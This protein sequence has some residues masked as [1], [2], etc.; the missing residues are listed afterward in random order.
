MENDTTIGTAENTDLRGQDW[1]PAEVSSLVRDY[2]TMLLKELYGVDYS[3]TEHRTRLLPQLCGRSHASV[4]RKCQNVSAVLVQHG[5]PYIDGYKPLGNYQA[6]LASETVSYLTQEPYVGAALAAAPKLKPCCLEK[7]WDSLDVPTLREECPDQLEPPS[8]DSQWLEDGAIPNIARTQATNET[9]HGLGLQFVLHV[10]R[11]ILIDAGRRDLADRVQILSRW[12]NHS[13]GHDVVSFRGH[14][15]GEVFVAVKTTSLGKH[16]PFFVTGA[17]AALS[18]REQKRFV[19]YRV[20]SCGS[21][22]RFYAIEG[23]LFDRCRLVP[24]DY[25]A[26]V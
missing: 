12:G 25:L 16:F 10:E 5:L 6:L 18:R 7:D 1:T 23:D 2:F 9:L 14:D 3:K 20:Y 26:A 13:L 19:L 11:R 15:G 4:Q 17:E 22:T 24:A 21:K 8:Q